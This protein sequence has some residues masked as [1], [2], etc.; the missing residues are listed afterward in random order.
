MEI[1]H[2]IKRLNKMEFKKQRDFKTVSEYVAYLKG[3]ND[4]LEYAQEMVNN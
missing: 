2:M 4:G 3:C 1:K